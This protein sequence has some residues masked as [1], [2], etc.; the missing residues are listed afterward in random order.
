MSDIFISY[1]RHDK[2]IVLSF[3]KS[4]EQK[5]GAVCWID[6][7]GIE[8]GSQFE[9]VIV[10][11]IDDSK[12]VLFMLSDYS[13]ESKWTK[14]EVLYA[15]YEGKRIVPIIVDGKGLRKWFKFHF[16]NIDYVDINSQEQ[17]EKLFKNLATWLG[18]KLPTTT[19]DIQSTSQPHHKLKISADG[20]EIKI[21]IIDGCDLAL[22]KDAA[23]KCYIGEF[24]INEIA[25]KLKDVTESEGYAA[26]KGTIGGALSGGICGGLFFPLGITGA[27]IG[28]YLGYKYKKHEIRAQAFSSILAKLNAQYGICLKKCE[29]ETSDFMVELDRNIIK[30]SSKLL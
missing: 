21:N 25:E 30:K 18:V 15:E 4:I 24:P 28:G 22:K 10:D 26:L 17:Q 12:V 9:D 13:L 19:P 7:E 6:L 1:S 2:E 8:Y 14:R 23:K 29:S 27:V 11:A 20:S 3:V 5:F 16:G